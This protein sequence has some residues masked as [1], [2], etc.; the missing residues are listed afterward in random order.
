[1]DRRKGGSSTLGFD[2]GLTTSHH[3]KELVT[4]Q[5]QSLEFGWALWINDP[6]DGIWI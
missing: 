1:M 2:V 5:K 6:S 4:K 3:R